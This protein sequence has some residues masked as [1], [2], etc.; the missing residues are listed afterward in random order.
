MI[1]IILQLL[2]AFIILLIESVNKYPQI[3]FR[4]KEKLQEQSNQF[5]FQT[6][7]FNQNVQQEDFKQVNVL[8]EVYHSKSLFSHLLNFDMIY[9]TLYL[10]VS[11]ISVFSLPFA[12]T[13][14]FDIVKRNQPLQ[15]VL[16]VIAINAKQLCLI[17][18]LAITILYCFSFIGF[19]LFWEHFPELI[20]DR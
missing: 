19:S 18:M 13:L 20:K 1:L 6:H 3:S 2:F 11:I 14:M 16:K 12:S 4:I 5:Q 10:L 17:L 15:Q 9:Y 7:E 8:Q